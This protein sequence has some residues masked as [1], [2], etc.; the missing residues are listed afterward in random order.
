[1]LLSALGFEESEFEKL[2][3]TRYELKKMRAE[4]TTEMID[5]I[6]KNIPFLV[7]NGMATVQLDHKSML[8][9]QTADYQTHA[10][11]I[12]VIVTIGKRVACYPLCFEATDGTSSLEFTPILEDILK[13]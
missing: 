4:N 13:V 9:N 10:L 11:C 7:V 6:S 12:C 1:M 5:F 2:K 3:V 8:G